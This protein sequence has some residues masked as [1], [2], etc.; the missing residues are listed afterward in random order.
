MSLELFK[1]RYSCRNF[2]KET[3]EDEILKEIFRGG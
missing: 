3:I 1:T 2:K